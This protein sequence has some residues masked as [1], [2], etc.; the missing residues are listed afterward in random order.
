MRGVTL[1]INLIDLEVVFSHHFRGI[2]DDVSCIV[3]LVAQEHGPWGNFCGHKFA[4]LPS[5]H[6]A[7][8]P[9]V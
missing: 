2:G 6:L 9:V 7:I 4:L 1:I 5:Y 8:L 3:T